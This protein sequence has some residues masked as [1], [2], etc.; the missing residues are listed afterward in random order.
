MQNLPARS[1][2]LRPV[3]CRYPMLLSK[4]LGAFAALALSSATSLA[5]DP[6]PAWAFPVV[7]PGTRGAPDDGKPKRV[8][9]STV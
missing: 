8:P 3:L 4:F 5:A 9:D 6:I 2:S 7:P 1:Y